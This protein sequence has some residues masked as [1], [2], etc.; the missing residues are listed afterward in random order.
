MT[1]A[2]TR[3][4]GGIYAAVGT[5]EDVFSELTGA[6][7]DQLETAAMCQAGIALSDDGV[8]LLINAIDWVPERHYAER[9]PYRMKIASL[10]YVPGFTR[11]AREGTVPVFFHTHPGGGPGASRLDDEVEADLRRLAQVRTGKP[12][13]AALILGGSR[14]KPTF[15]ARIYLEPDRPPMAAEKLRV[16]GRQVRILPSPSARYHF[17]QEIFD[18]QVRA[19]GPEGQAVLRSLRIGVV[20]GSGTG[21]PT[22][23]MLVRLGAGQVIAIDDDVMTKTNVTRI[24]QSSTADAGR[25]KVHV[26]ADEGTRIGLDTETIPIDGRV[27]SREV[28][29]RLRHCDLVFGCTHDH[30]GRAVLSRLAYF[31]LVP[32]I[33][34]GAMVDTENAE[35]VREVIGRVTTV[36]PGTACLLCRGVI[37]RDRMRWEQLDPAQREQL[38]ADG[39]VAPLGDPDPSVVSYTTV[40]AGLAVSEMLDRLFAL[41]EPEISSELLWRGLARAIS[42]HTKA[43]EPRCIC[44]DPWYWGRGDQPDFLGMMWP[45]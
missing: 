26:L 27:T 12:F 15:S 17:D 10:G 44:G 32:V 22:F 31:Y 3:E 20:G 4:T 14:A 30:W 40:T 42:R 39:Y 7:D 11:A 13:F 23:E 9:L 5:T 16:V 38:V 35:L 6:L 29:E 25:K 8:T 1:I 41:G 2:L 21:S 36:M 37:D 33:D 34:M 43:P 24:H 18:R 28:A 45:G 19:F